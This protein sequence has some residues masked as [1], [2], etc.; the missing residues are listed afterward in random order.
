[1]NHTVLYKKK[2]SEETELFFSIDIDS[3]EIVMENSSLRCVS[4]T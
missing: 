4:N 3:N 1:M 2:D